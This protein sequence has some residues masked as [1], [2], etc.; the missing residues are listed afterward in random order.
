MI[1]I[2]DVLNCILQDNLPF[3]KKQINL[4]NIFLNGLMPE[5]PQLGLVL[6]GELAVSVILVRELVPVVRLVVDEVT[7]HL[8]GTLALGLRAF[9]APVLESV[10]DVSW[11]NLSLIN[12]LL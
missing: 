7:D 5:L 1:I 12:S 11:G 4:R 3:Y 6:F 8:A 9:G 10:A 2:H